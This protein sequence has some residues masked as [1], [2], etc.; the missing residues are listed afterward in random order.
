MKRICLV[1]A[2]AAMAL[3][4]GKPVSAGVVNQLTFSFRN[5]G[6]QGLGDTLT[7]SLQL[8]TTNSTGALVTLLP[9]VQLPS[10][11]PNGQMTVSIDTE[12]TAACWIAIVGDV[13]LNGVQFPMFAFSSD[14]TTWK[15]PDRLGRLRSLVSGC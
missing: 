2:V 13:S 11:G 7:G 5:P 8:W 6:P 1:V 3:L 12:G 4:G 15:D 10:L 14:P 9:A